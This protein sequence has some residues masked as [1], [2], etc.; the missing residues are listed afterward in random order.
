MTR[1]SRWELS[2]GA[3]AAARGSVVAEV[4]LSVPG[5]VWRQAEQRIQRLRPPGLTFHLRGWHL[6][7]AGGGGGPDSSPRSG[8][9]FYRVTLRAWPCPKGTSNLLL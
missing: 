5:A 9:S 8:S 6:R 3:R 7:E 4:S 1:P 2:R